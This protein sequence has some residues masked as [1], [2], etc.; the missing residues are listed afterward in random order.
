[1]SLVEGLGVCGYEWGWDFGWGSRRLEQRNPWAKTATTVEVD[2]G[3]FGKVARAPLAG[4]VGGNR[5]EELRQGE[6]HSNEFVRG[7]LRRQE[8]P[9]I[10]EG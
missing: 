2:D 5:W 7:W 9:E 1:M 6:I 8:L 10:I 3:W 4:I